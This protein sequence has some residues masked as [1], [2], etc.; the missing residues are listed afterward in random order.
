MATTQPRPAT[1]ARGVGVHARNAKL[2]TEYLRLEAGAAAAETAGDRSTA[3]RLRQKMSSIASA[4]TQANDG[5][6]GPILMR[7]RLDRTRSNWADYAQAARLGLW[8]AFL[9]WDPARG[10]TF[11]GFSRPYMEGHVRRAVARYE[12]NGKSYEDFCNIPKVR[13]VI[14]AHDLDGV[15]PQLISKLSGDGDGNGKLTAKSVEVALM[16]AASSLDAPVGDGDGATLGDL[17]AD[18][19]HDEVGQDVDPRVLAE[20]TADLSPLEL[21]VML[22]RGVAQDGRWPLDGSGVDSDYYELGAMLGLN[23][24]TLRAMHRVASSVMRHGPEIVK[25]ALSDAASQI[26]R[27]KA[28]IAEAYDAGRLGEVRRATGQY[29]VDESTGVL[30]FTPKVDLR[31]TAAVVRD[32]L[33]D[34]EVEMGFGRL[35]V[36]LAGQLPK[37]ATV[38]VGARDEREPST[39]DLALPPVVTLTP[40]VSDEVELVLATLFDPSD[41]DP[42]DAA[43]LDEAVLDA[44]VAG[45]KRARKRPSTPRSRGGR[46]SVPESQMLLF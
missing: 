42:E 21:W 25:V 10:T 44:Y 4:F 46:R 40:T 5:L 26:E 27:Q 45:R 6:I 1:A 18:Q 37:Q 43:D 41:L 31:L 11:G 28:A 23:R 12:H 29:S 19:S 8:E 33:S 34:L 14:E 2:R 13:E 36:L 30:T 17:I 38:E 32:E 9:K 39:E 35:K 3:M 20:L 15:D 7:Y 22:R 24:E 16:S